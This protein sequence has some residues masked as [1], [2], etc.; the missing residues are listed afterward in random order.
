LAASSNLPPDLLKFQREFAGALDRPAAG[1]LAVYRN[2][3]VK[4]AVDAL[5]DNYPIVEQ[6]LGTE[7]F[8]AVSVD[9]A[10]RRPPCGPVL[11]LYGDAFPGWI[12]EQP[13]VADLPYLSDVARIERLRLECLMA[14]YAEPL[15][16]EQVRHACRLDGG[17]VCLHPAVRFAW[18]STPAMS[19]WLA[20][21]RGF[22][23]ELEPDWQ[24][25]GALFARPTPFGLHAPRIGR[26]AYRLLSGIRTCETLDASLAAAAALHPDEDCTAVLASLVNLGVFAAPA[27]QRKD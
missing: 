13:W 4:G 14:A 25:E 6:I 10:T 22:D 15:T 12:D 24:P 2:T 9:F 8:E 27:A 20:H 19:I 23:A 5:R 3:V 26:A 11:A 7:M 21:Q 18:L 1:A 17:R 16:S